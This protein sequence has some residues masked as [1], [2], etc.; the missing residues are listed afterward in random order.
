[1]ITALFLNL[2]TAFLNLLPTAALPTDATNAIT[3]AGSYLAL[4]N[5]VVPVNT[6][7]IILGSVLTIELG[8]FT[9]KVV[10]FVYKKI[11]TIS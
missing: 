1:M 2:V 4:I 10:K 3:T 8:I 5:Q 6:L 9:F 7:L 11:P